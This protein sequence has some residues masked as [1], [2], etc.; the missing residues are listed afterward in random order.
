[1]QVVSVY[2][3]KLADEKEASKDYSDKLRES[4]RVRAGRR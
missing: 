3:K 1:M 2:V 4:I